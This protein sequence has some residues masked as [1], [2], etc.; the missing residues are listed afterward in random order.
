MN[1]KWQL[2]LIATINFFFIYYAIEMAF[3]EF[4]SFSERTCL[5]ILSKNPV[6]H[7]GWTF[8]KY[9]EVC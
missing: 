6:R 1:V 5:A 9:A 7:D 3:S 4:S 2:F 8:G